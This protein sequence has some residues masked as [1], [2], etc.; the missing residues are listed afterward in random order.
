[1][2]RDEKMG[3]LMLIGI[4]VIKYRKLLIVLLVIWFA[5]IL[6]L[7]KDAKEGYDDANRSGGE[8]L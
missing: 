3:I 5:L 4:M 7:R 1:M 2:E 8:D 6:S